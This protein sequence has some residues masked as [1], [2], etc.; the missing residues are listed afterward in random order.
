M[1]RLLL[2]FQQLPSGDVEIRARAAS[3]GSVTE[4][5]VPVFQSGPRYSVRT[6]LRYRIANKKLQFT[7]VLF[8]PH[9]VIEHAAKA[10]LTEVEGGTKIEPFMG[11]TMA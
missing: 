3:S 2:Q 11:R 6:F 7:Y 9:K 8:N 4:L 10:V 5:G 1:R